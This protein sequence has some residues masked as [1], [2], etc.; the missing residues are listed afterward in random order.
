MEKL[1]YFLYFTDEVQALGLWNNQGRVK[2]SWARIHGDK[3]QGYRKYLRFIEPD[4]LGFYCTRTASVEVYFRINFMKLFAIT[5]IVFM[6]GTI[7]QGASLK[8]L[9]DESLKLLSFFSSVDGRLWSPFGIYNQVHG[10]KIRQVTQVALSYKP[11]NIWNFFHIQLV[12]FMSSIR[13]LITIWKRVVSVFWKAS[14]SP[15]TLKQKNGVS[16]KE[17]TLERVFK[18]LQYQRRKTRQI[19]G[20]EGSPRSFKTEVTKH[21]DGHRT[22]VFCNVSKTA[23]FVVRRVTLCGV[24]S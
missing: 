5:R 10:D 1:L 12:F 13:T 11:V 3:Y 23:R 8:C 9:R 21:T 17:S 2:L 19:S 20:M 16:S 22:S 14:F 18:T 7:W 6:G 4:Q 24:L 15:S